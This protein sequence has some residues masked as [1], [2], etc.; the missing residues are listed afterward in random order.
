MKLTSAQ[1]AVLS[2]GL[3]RNDGI[4][5]LPANLRGGAAQKLGVKLVGDRLAEELAATGS[6]PVWRKDDDHKP[7]ALRITTAGLEAIQGSPDVKGS[8]SHQKGLARPKGE[9]SEAAR[10][11]D[12]KSNYQNGYRTLVRCKLALSYSV[13][14]Q[15]RRFFG[16]PIRHG[17]QLQ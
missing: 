17:Y 2:S 8:Q 12:G 5:Q 9:P 13:R 7:I 3:R 11:D 10:T 1:H 4:L 6:M 15:H 14:F 16:L